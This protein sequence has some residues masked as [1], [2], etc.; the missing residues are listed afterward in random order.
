MSGFDARLAKL[1][2]MLDTE[3]AKA[4]AWYSNRLSEMSEIEKLR[5]VWHASQMPAYWDAVTEHLGPEYVAKY[6]PMFCPDD[7]PNTLTAPVAIMPSSEESTHKVTALTPPFV[8]TSP[9]TLNAK[10]FAGSDN[11]TETSET[12]RYP[13]KQPPWVSAGVSKATWYRN[14]AKAALGLQKQVA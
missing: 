7:A 4:S 1:E 14:K 11:E 8:E 5:R 6:R 10:P 3:K 9:S 2:T 12:T 13:E